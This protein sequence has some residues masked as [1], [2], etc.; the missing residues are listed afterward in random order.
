MK[1]FAFSKSNQISIFCSKSN[2]FTKID[3][4]HNGMRF[5]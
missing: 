4:P 1:I 2:Y 5:S 3:G